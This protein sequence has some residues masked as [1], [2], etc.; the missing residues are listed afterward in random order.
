MNGVSVHSEASV[1]CET[2]LELTA[3]S[4]PFPTCT[5]LA[6][7]LIQHHK[8]LFGNFTLYHYDELSVYLK[9][10]HSARAPVKDEASSELH[11]LFCT[12]KPLSTTAYCT[13]TITYLYHG[14]KNM[15]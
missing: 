13:R 7:S 4:N 15:A 2:M 12:A 10:E 9:T 6:Q 3:H 11:L 14:Q 8:Q 5:I 1:L